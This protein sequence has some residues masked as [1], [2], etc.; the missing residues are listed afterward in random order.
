MKKKV[1]LQLMELAKKILEEP[2]LSELGKLKAQA[3]SLYEKIAILE[4]LE[5]QLQEGEQASFEE[6]LDS[7]S[8]REQNWFRDPQPVPEPENKE[9]LIEPATEKIKDIVAQMP[10]ES[11]EMDQ[12]LADILPKVRHIKNDWEEI[13]SHY[14]DTPVFERKETTADTSNSKTATPEIKEEPTPEAEKPKSL[15]DRLNAGVSIGLNDRLAFI[16]HLFNGNAD[17]YTRVLSQIN[18]MQNYQEVERF[19]HEQIKPDYNHWEE[20]EEFAT[21]FLG[22]L[23]RGFN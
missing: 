7:K 5:L 22:H 10:L 4:Y 3:R 11:E 1:Q 12:L 2:S 19:L 14:R 23:E 21:R 17:D 13:A 20:K 16:K 9:E 8:Y 18:T 6:S 15:N